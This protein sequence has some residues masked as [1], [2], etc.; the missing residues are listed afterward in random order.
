MSVDGDPSADEL[1][2]LRELP[3]RAYRPRS[4]LRAPAHLVPRAAAPV[5]D[6]HNHL[7]RWLGANGEWTAPDVGE[8]IDVMDAC[9][10]AS[11]VNLDGMWGDELEANLER[12]DRAHPRRFSTF[13]HLDWRQTVES[14]FGE[15]MAASLR[16]SVGRGARGLKIWKHLG[17]RFRDHRD[18][19]LAPD[20]ERLDP[21]WATAAELGVPVTIHVADPI[22]FFD[23]IDERNERLEELL[24]NPDW[25]FGRPGLPSFDELMGSF[26]RLVARHPATTFIGAHVACAA[27]D[28]VWVGRMLDTYPNVHADI[29]ARVAELGRQPRAA[30][31]LVLRH[32]DRFLFGVDLFP[33]DAAAY[34]INFRFLE[35][36]DEHFPY[37]AEDPPPQGR[38][39]VSGLGL[40]SGILAQVYA[41]NARRLI[42]GLV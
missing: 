5:V 8:L 26:E 30:R 7:G 41:D 19:L 6:A 40:P 13:A 20:D 38:W 42:P 34:A 22:A 36:T 21:V 18:R 14:G 9:N 27:E 24:A 25:W 39:A 2:R 16:D 4:R 10:V 23:P 11:I 33:P 1:R 28:L 17:L 35:T 15:R 12:Y 37:D 31:E 3:L 32:A 29:A